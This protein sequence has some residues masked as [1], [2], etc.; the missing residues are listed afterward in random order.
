MNESRNRPIRK[1]NPGTL[2]SDEEV[3]SQF[4]VR[5]H[6]LG[7]M[8]EALRDNVDSPSCQHILVVAPRGRGKS[9]LLA[10]VAA[11]L[12]TDDSLS[13]SLLPVRF[14]EES[15]EVFNIADF[16][17]ETLFYL[18]K[19]I[20]TGDP[21]LSQALQKTHAD[22]A[23]RWSE[24]ATGEHAR[25]AVLSAADRLGKKLVLMVENLQALCDDVDADFDWK[26]RKVLQSEPQIMLLATATSRFEGLEDATQP[27]F[28]LFR[29]VDL[30]P[31]NTEE[32]YRLWQMISGDMVSK[33]EIR[34]LEI[35]TGGSPRLLV[36]VGE[37]ARHQSLR[38][39]MEE[40]VKLID[41]HTEYFRGHLE[42]FAK[43]ERRVYLAVIDL[44]RPSRTGEIAARARMDV[45][46]VSALLGRLVGQGVVT[47][48]GPDRKRQYAAAERLYSIYYKLRRQRDEA[49]VVQHLIHFMAVFYH[50]DKLAE[51]SGKL[52]L[53]AR[54]SLTIYV[55][56]QR[57]IIEAPELA[58]VLGFKKFIGPEDEVERFR[59]NVSVAQALVNKGVRQ[60]QLGESETE[61]A[62]YDEVIE[63]FGSSDA[64]ELQEQVAW[65]LI[66][67]GITQGRLGE[68][69]AAIATYD[70]V[71]ERFGSSDAPELQKR[72]ARALIN[73]GVRQGQ[74]G[75]SET[76]IATYDE[77]IE[78]FGS[79]D[80]PGLQEQVA[81][82]LINKG[83]TQGQ[84]GESEAAIATCDEVIERFGS[85]DAP[86]L[87]EQV[88]MALVFKG[89]RQGQLGE[90]E[91]AI[92]TYDEVIERFGS[93]DA[94]E[95][96]K[97][98]ARALINKGVRQ[99]QLGESETEI[100]TYDEVIERFGSSDA[101]GLQEQVAWALINKGITQG[102][103]GES[104]V[105]IATYDEVIERF[106]SSDAPEL[107]KRVAQALVNKG[108]RQGQLGESETEIATYDEVI[109]RFGSSDAPEL[110]KQV[111][112][113]LI[114]KGITQGR[115]GESEA[116]IATYDEVIERFGSSDAPEL[117]KRVAMALVNKGVRQGQLGESETEIA[118]YDEVIERFGSSDAPG[119]QEQVAWALIFKGITQGQLGESEAAI[120]TYDE[121]IERFGSSD[122]PGLQEQVAMA[123]VF[124]G[125][126]QGQLGESEVAIATCDEVIERF[127]SS[128]APGLQKRVAK[129]L[130]LKGERQIEIGRME[131]ALYT[132]D[133]LERRFGTLA[134]EADITFDWRARLMRTKALLAQEKFPAAVDAFSL[135]Y[136]TLILGNETMMREILA[137]VIDL[138]AAEASAH[139]LVQVLSSDRR[140]A[141]TLEPLVVALRELA[142]ESVRAPSEILDVAADIHKKIEAR[143]TA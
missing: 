52:K 27:F 56:I 69:E 139:H 87:Q 12:R 45:R 29:I 57:A 94:P 11:E 90:S 3:I 83:I 35:L 80:A 109:E 143:R 61:I 22:L 101:P 23:S 110:Q 82:A 124:K 135:V 14:M 120:A 115:L 8:L 32:C 142:G 118:T 97:R 96:Q 36:I 41:D 7:T 2:Q 107:K 42:S 76:E 63:R 46:K 130:V 26:L 95:L 4:V 25:T 17:L 67:K 129:A 100:A 132:C 24:R 15:Q 77:V 106:G 71:I 34:P 53:E 125:I 91:T 5:N 122:A 13:K 28:E 40:L 128:D 102:Q 104:E 98:V 55:G 54:E 79:S 114:L 78:R 99:G 89:V 70:E 103:L 51:V 33:H 111:A 74:L 1:F 108:V 112:W 86:G 81:W 50:G 133:E 88:A 92:A 131:E 68:S 39:L 119:L 127:G 60:G 117:Q 105:A 62:T 20:E 65:A 19:E 126:T 18:A 116:A 6:Q 49:A 134:D 47:M 9:M 44:W 21:D 38:Q 137:L 73:K 72:V 10:R 113:A 75:E 84:L 123:L 138:I 141:E 64:P 93:S 58:G 136:A 48:D 85:S 30:K 16:W 121:V 31:L 66:L 140:K 43:S 59:S 37:F